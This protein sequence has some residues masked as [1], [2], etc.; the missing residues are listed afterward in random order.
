MDINFE[1]GEYKFVW[2]KNKAEINKKKHKISFET[3]AEVFLDE[4]L[5][6]DYDEFNSDDEERNR[7][8]GKVGRILF[9]IYT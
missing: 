5:I 7:V 8:I 9:V 1:L 4:N 3:A 2:D 6:D